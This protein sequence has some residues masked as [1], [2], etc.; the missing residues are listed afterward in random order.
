MKAYERLL[1]YV[2]SQTKLEEGSDTHPSS[3]RQFDL[4]N[5]L[6]Q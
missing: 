3:L 6:E 5:I 4:A 1:K 2:A